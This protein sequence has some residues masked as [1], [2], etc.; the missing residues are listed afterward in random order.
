MTFE[1]FKEGLDILQKHGANGYCIAAEHDIF[2]AASARELK[3][4][5]S[6][7]RKLRKL[8]WIISEES[9]AAFT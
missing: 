1:K 9:W 7:I 3:M 8:G 5:L 4:P 6:E 2:Y